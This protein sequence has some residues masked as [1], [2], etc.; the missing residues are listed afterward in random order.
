MNN[1]AM[2]PICTKYDDDNNLHV[3]R[4]LIKYDELL[5]D[6]E[7]NYIKY[8]NSTRF[9]CADPYFFNKESPHHYTFYNDGYVLDDV[10]VEDMEDL[11]YTLFVA[12]AVSEKRKYHIVPN[13]DVLTNGEPALFSAETDE[14]AINKFMNREELR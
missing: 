5:N 12:S 1:Y 3:R 4:V 13:F 11:F 6:S 8:F 14:E 7:D 9:L 10:R 2:V